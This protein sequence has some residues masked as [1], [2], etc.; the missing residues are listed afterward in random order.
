MNK[1]DSN[2]DEQLI[3][4]IGEASKNA[5]RVLYIYLG[6]LVYITVT[7]LNITNHQLVSKKEFSCQYYK[8]TC[9]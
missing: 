3:N 9:L 2:Y 8:L 5:R 7:V 1:A 6:I 4:V